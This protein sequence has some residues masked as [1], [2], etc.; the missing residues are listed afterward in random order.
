MNPSPSKHLSAIGARSLPK[1]G[2]LRSNL[3]FGESREDR[4][5]YF[6]NT[7]KSYILAFK[8]SCG[9]PGPRLD[10]WWANKHRLGLVEMTDGF[11][12]SKGKHFWP[13]DSQSGRLQLP[14]DVNVIRSNLLMLFYQ[15]AK[16]MRKSAKRENRRGVE[17]GSLDVDKMVDTALDPNDPIKIEYDPFQDIS[18]DHEFSVQ[19][20]P[21]VRRSSRHQRREK[22]QDRLIGMARAAV[23]ITLNSENEEEQEQ[24]V[25]LLDETEPPSSPSNPPTPELV[26]LPDSDVDVESGT[27]LKSG[28]GLKSPQALQAADRADETSAQP[29]Q[30]K[31]QLEATSKLSMRHSDRPETPRYL[32]QPESHS[33]ANSE[34]ATQHVEQH[35]EGSLQSEQQEPPPKTPDQLEQRERHSETNSELSAQPS[36]RHPK[37]ISQLEQLAPH[38]DRRQPERTTVRPVH[39]TTAQWGRSITASDRRPPNQ[40]Q[41]LALQRHHYRTISQRDDSVQSSES[42]VSQG[43]DVHHRII[44]S[45]NYHEGRNKRWDPGADFSEWSLQFVV[46]KLSPASNVTGF[47]FTLEMPYVWFDDAVAVG[48]ERGFQVLQQRFL[49]KI[50]AFVA[51]YSGAE[52]LEITIGPILDTNRSR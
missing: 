31:Q 37:T 3:G 17:F 29:G 49:R 12:A 45:L 30:L 43:S 28:S 34:A 4:S 5:I 21:P 41:R 13:P 44:Y 51:S 35:P 22:L 9:T 2:R 47:S 40:L 38:P 36:D 26:P 10:Q 6:Y 42:K 18:F 39:T 32:E 11:L 52:I 16:Q 24:R 25:A 14:A 19:D 50:R 8:S 33:K 46:E 7:I 15:T 1:I 20:A 27:E 48:D 23:R